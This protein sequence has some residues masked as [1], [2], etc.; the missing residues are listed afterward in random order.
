MSENIKITKPEGLDLKKRFFKKLKMSVCNI[1]RYPELAAE[2]VPRAFNY[3]IKLIALL[4]IF[5]CIG[6]IYDVYKAV[7]MGVNYI[8]NEFPNFS[9]KDGILSIESENELKYE[10]T[11]YLGKV[12]IDTKTED[13]EKINQYTKEIEEQSS[14]MLILK[15]KII[16]KNEAIVGTPTYEYK[17]LLNQSGITEFTKQD[18]INFAKGTQIISLYVSLFITLFIYALIMFLLSTLVNVLMISVFGYFAGLIAKV[19]MRYVAVFNMS[20]YSITLSTLLNIIYAVVNIFTDFNIQYFE[21]MYITVAVIYLF[22]AIFMIKADIIKRQAELIKIAEVQKA[23]KKELEE[24]EP[25]QE[26]KKEDKGEEKEKEE[27]EPQTKNEPEPQGQAAQ[28]NVTENEKSKDDKE[29]QDGKE[30]LC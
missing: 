3:L 10:N 27:K 9:Y 24:Q 23:V 16:I 6:M 26:D 12:I 18:I 1:E 20:V 21:V 2:G 14:G 5:I 30:D 4:S 8:E 19:R 28:A 15:D 29:V 25:E 13:A 17:E 22:A 11:E 7:D